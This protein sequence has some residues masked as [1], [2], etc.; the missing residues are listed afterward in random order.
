MTLLF[1]QIILPGSVSHAKHGVPNE[2][3]LPTMGF[4]PVAFCLLR[5]RAISC[6]TRSD[7][8]N[9]SKFTRVLPE[10]IGEILFQE[11]VSEK[12]LSPSILC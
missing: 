8:Q 2:K 5:R 11:Y 3:F 10:M 12:N 7:I 9:R 4:E 6:A 1:R